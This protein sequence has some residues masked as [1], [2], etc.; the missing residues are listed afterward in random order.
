M[1]LEQFT[2]SLCAFIRHDYRFS[3]AHRVGDIALSVQTLKRLPRL[4]FP[5][6]VTIMV[7]EHIQAQQSK[8]HLIDFL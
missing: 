7:L 6:S 4:T 1:L 8:D 3:L 2:S 5:G